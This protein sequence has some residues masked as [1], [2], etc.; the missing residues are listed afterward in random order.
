[1]EADLQGIRDGRL[2]VDVDL[3]EA[4]VAPHFRG[5]FELRRHR[6][7]R[8]APRRPEV[9]HEDP[10]LA[11]GVGDRV[12]GEG[13]PMGHHLHNCTFVHRKVAPSPTDVNFTPV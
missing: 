5:E 13:V 3:R 8:S 6:A 7:A 11:Q 9:D 1:M 4:V 12:L 2:L 10:F